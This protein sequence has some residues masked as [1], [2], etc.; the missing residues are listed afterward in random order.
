MYSKKTIVILILIPIF[1]SLILIFFFIKDISLDSPK[2]IEELAKLIG[3]FILTVWSLFITYLLT[4]H[5]ESKLLTL[6]NEIINSYLTK[7]INDI[8]KILNDISQEN[9]SKSNAYILE[10]IAEIDNKI[11][12]IHIDIVRLIKRVEEN[13]LQN[14][15][16]LPNVYNL[17]KRIHN[18]F[19]KYL[20]EKKGSLDIVKSK[21]TV[22][23]NIYKVD[24]L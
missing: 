19:D 12:A 13:T 22:I 11:N 18:E 16:P 24:K 9:E 2:F 4:K 21:L 20:H 1:L 15:L 3:T 8:E 6:L 10:T 23:K 14:K 7:Y 5:D 17:L